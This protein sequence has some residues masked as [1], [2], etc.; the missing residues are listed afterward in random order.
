L[1]LSAEK[2]SSLRYIALAIVLTILDVCVPANAQQSGP[3]A[4]VGGDSAGNSD[5]FFPLWKSLL[6][7]K[8]FLPPYGVNLVLLDL[9]GQWDVKNFSASVDGNE[10]ASVSGRANVHPFTY[11]PRADVWVFPFMNVFVTGGGVKLNV[12]ATGLDLP[13]GVGG[14]P[15]QVVRGD[16][17]IDLD[18]TGYYG[19]AGFVLMYA[20]RELFTSFDYSTVWTHLQASES[21]VSGSE[22]R[23]DTAS[24]RIGYNAG[25]VQPY[26]GGRWVKKI[27]HFEGTVSGPDGRPLTFAVDL[28]APVW[29]YTLGMHSLIA[30]H[31][32][33]VVEAGFGQ[34][35]HGLVNLG[36]R[37]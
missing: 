35:T 20:W 3:V 25:I 16:V 6:Q 14:R 15:P 24:F 9:S 19:G 29:N 31:I 17:N 1:K 33:V 36:Y 32:E 5:S 18:F 12:Q 30:R 7:G 23:T 2:E 28:Q 13:L 21:D 37:F 34:R 11:G 10:V 22:L 27:D 4:A 26:I 8:N